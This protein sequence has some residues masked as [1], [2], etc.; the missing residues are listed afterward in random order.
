VFLSL[1]IMILLQY[2]LTTEKHIDSKIS[3]HNFARVSS[4][5]VI[6]ALYITITNSQDHETHLKAGTIAA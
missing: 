5:S 6:C 2:N 3:R 4:T 1:L